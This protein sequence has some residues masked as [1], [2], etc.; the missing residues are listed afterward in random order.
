MLSK[1]QLNLLSDEL[2]QALINL[3]QEDFD[4]LFLYGSYATGNFNE[5]SDIDF[6]LVLKEEKVSFGKEI[7]KTGNLIDSLTLKYNSTIS[8]FPTSSIS[9]QKENTPFIKNIK[10]YAIAV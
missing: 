6:L 7:R 8:L 2:K 4:K 9:L 1:A 3:Y 5:D 10:S